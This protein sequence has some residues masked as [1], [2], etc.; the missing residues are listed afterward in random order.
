MRFNDELGRLMPWFFFDAVFGSCHCWSLCRW[1]VGIFML[2]SSLFLFIWQ[3][4]H[5][6][7]VDKRKNLYIFFL[8]LYMLYHCFYC[9]NIWLYE[10]KKVSSWFWKV[11]GFILFISK[12]YRII[13]INDNNNV[14]IVV[15]VMYRC[16]YVESSQ[17]YRNSIEK[18]KT[19]WQ[20]ITA[21]HHHL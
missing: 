16:V 11:H 21:C 6:V 13:I 2:S 19:T 10:W 5:W 8:M 18:I 20:H 14:V 1:N 3:L 4:N 9:V 15:S 12:A 17:N 7:S